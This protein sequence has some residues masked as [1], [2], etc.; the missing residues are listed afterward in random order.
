M[1]AFRDTG[2]RPAIQAIRKVIRNGGGADDD[3]S[4]IDVGGDRLAVC[5]DSVSFQRHRPEG[6]SFEQFG[7]TAAAVN[8]SDLAAM[9]ARPIGV[10]AALMVPEDTEMS[11]IEAIMSGMDQCAEFSGTEIIGGDT[12]PGPGVVAGTAIGAMDGREPMTRSGAKKG[13]LIAV[14]GPLG[15]PAAGFRALEK[16]FDSPDCIFSLY[17]PIPRTQ[18]GIALAETGKVTSCMDLSDGLST[19]LN[20]ICRINGLGAAVEWDLIPR[21][22]GVDEAVEALGLSDEETVMDWGGEYELMFTFDRNDIDALRSTDVDFTI[23][24]FMT[25]DGSVLLR[26]DGKYREVG[27]GAY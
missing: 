21:A 6:M 23:I 16:G 22:D 19:A 4:V 14:T 5:T 2:E 11:D 7:W 20:T 17:V 8:L 27:D 24:G 26:R 10:M 9:G 12:K 3:A 25:D 18:E 13:D 15:G 1:T